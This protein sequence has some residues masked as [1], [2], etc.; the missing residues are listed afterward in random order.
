MPQTHRLT[1]GK[2]I[3]IHELPTRGDDFH[4]D[5]QAGSAEFRKL[6]KTARRWQERLYAEGRSKLLLVF[7]AMDAGGKDGTIRRVLQ[8]INPQGIRV[9]SFKVPS[10]EE[11]ARDFLWRIHKA[12]PGAGMIGVFNRSQYEDVLVVRVHQLAAESVWQQRYQQI[13]Q[14]EKLLVETGTTILKFYLHISKEE[15]KRRFQER[16]E[17]PSKHWKFSHDDVK[18]RADWD[19]YMEAYEDALNRCTTSWAPWH[20]IPADQNWYR[21]LAVMRVIVDALE[22][23]DPQYPPAEEGLEGVTIPD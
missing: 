23:L 2:S 19:A 11:R 5:K 1:P 20:A 15:Q 17:D 18:K 8:G 3:R 9:T 12:V 13:N 10:K 4:L 16:L 14:F 7:Q 6:R 21:N 22:R